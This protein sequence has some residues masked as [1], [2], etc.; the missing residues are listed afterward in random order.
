MISCSE[1][2]SSEREISLSTMADCST[3]YPSAFRTHDKIY[4]LLVEAMVCSKFG[5]AEFF[6]EHCNEMNIPPNSRVLDV[7]CGVGP[8][9]IFLADQ[10]KCKVKGI[11]INPRAVRC[12]EANIEKYE[13]AK[14]LSVECA[15]FSIYSKAIKNE[16]WDFIISNPPIGNSSSSTHITS[17]TEIDYNKITQE[18]FAFLTN[19]WHSEEGLELL[20]FIFR[21]ASL[22]LAVNGKV[23]IVFCSMS[24]TTIEQLAKKA[25]RHGF[26]L[27]SVVD[28]EIEASSLGVRKPDLTTI[29]THIINFISKY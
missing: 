9:G 7:G 16:K 28:G 24:C 13:L 14:Y 26:V 23:L 22:H 6:S 18:Q 5:L 17:Y 10:K 12:C 1:N 19:S 15:D 27:E 2:S 20:D 21:Y 29:K 11:D 8:I 4:E 3:F 25:E